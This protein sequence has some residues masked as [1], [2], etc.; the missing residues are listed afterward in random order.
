MSLQLSSEQSVGENY[1]KVRHFSDPVFSVDPT[2]NPAAARHAV[3]SPTLSFL[4]RHLV[5][6]GD[7]PRFPST[8]KSRRDSAPNLLVT[9]RAVSPTTD[10][11]PTGN[12]AVMPPLTHRVILVVAIFG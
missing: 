12:T 9:P 1:D 4:L 11:D 8:S 7:V 3:R 10:D 6:S 5:L 2:S